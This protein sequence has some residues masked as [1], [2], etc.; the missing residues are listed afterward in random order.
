MATTITAKGDLLVGTGSATYDNL[1]VGTDG[2]TLVADSAET[3]GLK[4]QA[5]AAAGFVG[6]SLNNGA[7]AHSITNATLVT[8]TFNA[9]FFDTDGFHSTSSNTDRIT[10]P[11]GKGGKYLVNYL[12]YYDSAG[13]N[14]YP[15]Q[16]RLYKNGSTQIANSYTDV[17]D[18]SSVGIQFSGIFDLVAGDYLNIQ[19]YQASGDTKNLYTTSTEGQFSVQYLGA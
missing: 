17:Q 15:T 12:G 11:S 4:W 19:V 1:A 6:C 18:N 3:T 5:P 10:I 16:T 13:G 14:A 2:Y 7:T 9:E 8:L